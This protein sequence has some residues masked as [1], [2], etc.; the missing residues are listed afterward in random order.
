M[1]HDLAA[2]IRPHAADHLGD[3]GIVAANTVGQ[4]LGTAY[5]AIGH[6]VHVDDHTGASTVYRT[7]DDGTLERLPYR[8]LLTALRDDALT[9]LDV[10]AALPTPTTSAR[11]GV[12]RARA[13]ADVLRDGGRGAASWLR[14]AAEVA[15]D[16]LPELTE[17]ELPQRTA[18]PRPPAA[19]TNESRQARRVA[20]AARRHGDEAE[21]AA[22]LERWLPR[23]D[24]DELPLPAV[25]DAWQTALADLDPGKG[26]AVRRVGRT[27]FYAVLGTVRPIRSTGARRRVVT[28]RP[29]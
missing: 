18:T 23:L 1:S 9:A 3:V 24:V 20:D 10:A 26:R 8:A 13:T 7:A 19:P 21:L 16:A 29:A 5:A 4:H 6:R 2:L 27:R 25:W 12:A 28:I 11:R 17:D 14:K 15:R 22:V